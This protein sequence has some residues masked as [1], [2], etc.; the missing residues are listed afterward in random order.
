MK[1]TR[2]FSMTGSWRSMA[3][4]RVFGIGPCCCLRSRGQSAPEE[5]AAQAVIALAAGQFDEGGYA[6]FL[7]AHCTPQKDA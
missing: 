1:E 7:E 6:A 3:A 4:R 5:E 2:S